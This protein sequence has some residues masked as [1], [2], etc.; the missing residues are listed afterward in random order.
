MSGER[1][2]PRAEGRLGGSHEVSGKVS[3]IHI[4]ETRSSN[5]WAS[6]SAPLPSGF[7]L[8]AGSARR[9]ALGLFLLAFVSSVASAQNGS[10]A[11][12]LGPQYGT[13]V[14]RNATVVPVTSP[15]IPNASVLIQ[16][17]RIAAVGANVAT[18]TGA[19]VIDGQG[20]FVYP[21]LIDSGTRLGLT[22]VG[23]VPG[24]DDTREL[25]DFN[26]QPGITTK[27]EY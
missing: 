11:G 18:P 25:G 10:S 17:G 6:R 13:F 15:R 4:M 20:L 21:G 23:G 16:N 8:G 19:T 2:A 5:L 1:R 7:A 22:E 3:G 24:P 26:P 9:S 14:I 12:A 27:H